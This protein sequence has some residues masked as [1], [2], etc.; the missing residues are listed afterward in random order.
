M[1][2]PVAATER[3]LVDVSCGQRSAGTWVKIGDKFGLV[4]ALLAS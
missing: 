3:P 1:W 4:D 2:T